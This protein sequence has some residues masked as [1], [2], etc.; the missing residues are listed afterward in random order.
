MSSPR[1]LLHVPMR[2]LRDLPHGSVLQCLVSSD[3]DNC[4][5]AAAESKHGQRTRFHARVWNT[6]AC[7][8]HTSLVSL[9]ITRSARALE[10]QFAWSSRGSLVSLM[11]TR[12]ARALED[13][14]AWSSRT[15][16]ATLMSAARASS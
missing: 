11:I 15:S 16:L 8:S 7:S 13:Q 2:S 12:S 10:D 3:K 6:S 14:F 4:F 5:A 9:M 1:G